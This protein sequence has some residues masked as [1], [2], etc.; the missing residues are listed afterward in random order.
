MFILLNVE[1][2]VLEI[3]SRPFGGAK[4][5]PNNSAAMEAC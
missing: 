3:N 2:R 5:E 4:H 1:N